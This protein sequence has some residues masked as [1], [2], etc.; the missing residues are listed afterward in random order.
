VDSDGNIYVV[1]SY[2]D[3]LLVFNRAG[4]FLMAIGGLGRETGKFYLPAGTWVD[5]RNRVFVADMFNGRVVI[6][7]YLETGGGGA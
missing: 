2:Y 3:H 6:F 4:T 5:G 1:E 7:Q